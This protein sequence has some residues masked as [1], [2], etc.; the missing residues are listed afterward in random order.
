MIHT[1]I[2]WAD[3]G[4]GDGVSQSENIWDISASFVCWFLIFELLNNLG[5]KLFL[6]LSKFFI[7]EFM[8]SNAACLTCLFNLEFYSDL[9]EI[10]SE[11]TCNI[12]GASFYSSCLVVTAKLVS[13]FAY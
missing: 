2:K 8:L 4:G 9:T 5:Y 11:V 1:R 3:M 10:I 6:I 7:S 13:L 12:P